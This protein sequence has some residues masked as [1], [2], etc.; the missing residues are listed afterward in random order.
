MLFS[1]DGR[2]D[3]VTKPVDAA[4]ESVVADIESQGFRLWTRHK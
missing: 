4:T 3:T 1:A 2:V